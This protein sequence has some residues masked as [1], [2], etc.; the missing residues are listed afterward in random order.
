LTKQDLGFVE[1]EASYN[2][3]PVRRSVQLRDIWSGETCAI[4]DVRTFDLKAED[5]AFLEFQTQ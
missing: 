4:A 2:L 5:V 1:F 3:G